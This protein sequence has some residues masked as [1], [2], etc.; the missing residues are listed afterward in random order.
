MR[1]DPLGAARR[2]RHD[3]RMHTYQ[4]TVAE[5]AQ[6]PGPEL[7]ERLAQCAVYRLETLDERHGHYP[8]PGSEF[9]ML[10][11]FDGAFFWERSA[12]SMDDDPPSRVDYVVVAVDPPQ[13]PATPTT[14]RVTVEVIG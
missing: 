9:D 10:D 3:G 12:E 1:F 11:H 8:L 14:V 6:G 2:P 7:R 4:V 5:T 13:P